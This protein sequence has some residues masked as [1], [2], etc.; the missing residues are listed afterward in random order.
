MVESPLRIM[1][2]VLPAA[3]EEEF[4]I[5]M[6]CCSQIWKKWRI[7]QMNWFDICSDTRDVQI[8]HGG[9]RAEPK[10]C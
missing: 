5:S 3:Q 9:H 10:A 4:S 8:Y 6:E 2:E 7:G 1:D